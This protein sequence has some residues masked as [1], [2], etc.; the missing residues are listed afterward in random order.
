MLLL[1]KMLRDLKNNAVQFFA[2]FFMSFL[3]LLMM[4]G[5]SSTTL[6]PFDNYLSDTNYKDI[7]VY[8]ENMTYN[9]AFD[10]KEID[11][12]EAVT[13]VMNEAGKAV[14][15]SGE[16]F[17]MCLSFISDNEIS[18]M[19]VVEGSEYE[20]GMDGVWIDYIWARENNLKVGQILDIKIDDTIINE[21]IRGL[22]YS[23]EYIYYVPDDTYV[24]PVY[25]EFGFGI[26]DISQSP[27]EALFDQ[28]LVTVSGIS[29]DRNL[30]DEEI[31]ELDK[32]CDIILSVLDNKLAIVT[33][34]ENIDQLKYYVEV[35][36]TY[37]IV[38]MV[39]S[40]IFAIIAIL[41]IIST[42][43]RII[44]S[45]RTTIGA[46]KAL[47][48]T[49]G[50]IMRH[51]ISYSVFIVFAGGLAGSIVGYYVLGPINYDSMVYYYLN[52]YEK[53]S[54]TQ[55]SV[56]YLLL[57]TFVAGVIGYF[58]NKNLLKRSASQILQPEAPKASKEGWYEKTRLWNKLRFATK[59]NVRDVSK[60]LL[61]TLIGL[62]G[63][64]VCSLL[65]FVAIG[66]YEVLNRSVSWTYGDLTRAKNQ[67][68]LTEGTPYEVTYDYAKEYKGQMLQVS[69]ADISFEGTGYSGYITVIS[70]GSNYYLTDEEGNLQDLPENG[71]YVTSKFSYYYDIFPGDIVSF[72]LKG[73]SEEVK[74]R[75]VGITKDPANQGLIFSEKSFLDTN[76]T[77]TPNKILTN[78]K[79]DKDLT[80]RTEISGVN[81][82][83]ELI[84]AS[85]NE[86]ESL[87][88][89]VYILIALG[90]ILG[91][92]VQY[93]LGTMSYNEKFKDMATLKVLGF[94][95]KE[96]KVLLLEQN[97]AIALIGGLI[98]M[99]LG[100]ETLFLFIDAMSDVDDYLIDLSPAPYLVS[101]VGTFAV[102]ILVNLFIVSKIDN[103]K[104]AEALKS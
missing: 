81:T 20:P 35:C 76:L 43:S 22:V 31:E 65:L 56:I 99:A 24:E 9:T 101:L 17:K 78:L 4:T 60:N 62:L 27:T 44:S 39:F 23:P 86:K 71:A 29:R 95:A 74:V 67:I 79:V 50:K 52:P 30:T 16:E 82:I 80:Q 26:M 1:I 37:E 57:L 25:G 47:G 32:M 88:M 18:N 45:Q 77:Y 59:W 46:L 102:T 15:D 98:G 64:L 51:Y 61:R 8:L 104:L 53:I 14:F 93:N 55:K 11:G 85:Q 28:M 21:V 69:S 48:F 87:I 38:G 83:D 12:I 70:K 94:Q 3:A 58:C 5:F 72:K 92:V 49:T 6:E 91:I 19:Y 103:I 34:K 96:L 33:P 54:F 68:T 90:I 7:D 40:N 100:P 36:E 97:A 42:M 75:I 73:D 89:Y 2:V 10:V 63:V 66:Y 41:G 13:L 84:E